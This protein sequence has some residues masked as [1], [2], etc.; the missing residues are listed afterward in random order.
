MVSR[1]TKIKQILVSPTQY[2]WSMVAADIT[3]GCYTSYEKA[4]AIYVWLADTISYD[5]SYSIHDADTAWKKKKGVC[6]AYCELFYRIGIA[7]GLDVRIVTGHGRGHAN[8]GR[9]LEDHC[10]IVVNRNSVM[11]Q[12]AFPEAIIYEKDQEYILNEFV[13]TNGLTARNAIM[14]EPTWGAGVVEDGRFIKSDHDMSWFDV[15]PCWMIF[16]HYPKN[17]A[18][19]LL[20]EYPF[21]SSDYKQLPYLHPSYA[22]YGFD[23][24]DLL[25]YFINTG[26]CDFPKIFPSFG[27]YVEFID[28]PISSMLRKG[29]VCEFSLVKKSKC[30][31]AISIESDFYLESDK[32]VWEISDNRC[33]ATILLHKTGVLNLSIKDE[34]TAN[35][36]NVLIEYKIKM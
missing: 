19:Q 22:E 29:M 20:G 35:K 25:S 28:I 34:N 3:K 18:D 2:D 9:V 30:S 10:W 15:D 26:S 11:S 5:T 24:K 12:H 14:I 8:V 17:P 6:Q 33:K 36:Y 23:A 27:K 13:A 21:S 32:S 16:T 31:L 4:K 1:I 7:C